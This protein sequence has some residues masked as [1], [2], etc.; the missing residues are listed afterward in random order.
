MAKIIKS[1]RAVSPRFFASAGPTSISTGGVKSRKSRSS[2]RL[3]LPPSQP[4]HHNGCSAQNRR[5][6]FITSSFAYMATIVQSFRSR[7]INRPGIRCGR[8][9]IYAVTIWMGWL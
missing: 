5:P 4:R 2:S 7:S 6:T 9:L 3:P 1:S 8:S